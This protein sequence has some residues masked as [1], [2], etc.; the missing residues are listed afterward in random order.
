MAETEIAY[1]PLMRVV[2]A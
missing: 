1:V 2:M